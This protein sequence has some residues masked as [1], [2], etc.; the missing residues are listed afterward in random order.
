M[1]VRASFVP[2][3]LGVATLHARAVA[4]PA[5]D[6]FVDLVQGHVRAEALDVFLGDGEWSRRAI[7]WKVV[8][9][10]AAPS[11][12]AFDLLLDAALLPE[13]EASTSRDV[14]WAL[15]PGVR[16]ALGTF[17]PPSPTFDARDGPSSL[18]A[19][20]DLQVYRGGFE[21]G[22]RPVLRVAPS[23]G[24]ID[25]DEAWAAWRGAH[26]HA[27][28][29][30]RDRWLGPG[31]RGALL[32]TD[33]A[34]P[35]PMGTIAAF[36]HLPG[37]LTRA[38]NF[39]FETSL[40][41]FD[42]PR[43]DVRHPLLLLADARW[44]P[45]PGLEIGATRMSL[46]GGEDRAWPSLGQILVPS[47]PHVYDDPE[48]EQPDQ[49]ELA[50]LDV[51]GC[52]PLAR[53]VGGPVE[54]IEAWWQYGAED[55]VM[56]EIGGVSVPSLAAVAF[57]YG[58]EAQLGPW[59]VTAEQARIFDDTFRWYTHHRVYHEGFTQDGRVLGHEAG[60][61]ALD[62]WARV[63][64]RPRPYRWMAEA[65][66]EHLQRIGVVASQGGNLLALATDETSRRV[67]V[68]VAFLRP[69]GGSVR[70][71]YACEHV[72]GADFVPGAT[73]WNHH[74]L[75]SWTSG[76]LGGTHGRVIEGH[77][78][79]RDHEESQRAS[80]N[81][82]PEE[83]TGVGLEAGGEVRVSPGR[84]EHPRVEDTPPVVPD[85]DQAGLDPSGGNPTPGKP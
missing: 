48:R 12:Q 41:W 64:Y 61:D 78:L 54:W 56:R 69:R 9:G 5:A 43:E 40:G 60:G 4:A 37:R 31:R 17:A 39:R 53:L 7:A 11:W 33:N 24:R 85:E 65:W 62:L 20:L 83:K 79:H 68:R 52:L 25:L 72:A 80:R 50:S 51:R 84:G 34:R 47:E 44:L 38:G 15:R 32:L 75:V 21:V 27:G 28:F 76:W 74:A 59:R 55:L 63:G 13:R 36:G 16:S 67:G 57:L 19:D 81:G 18:R 22:L 70:V 23:E 49:D 58:L 29:G 1:P 26:L 35:P 46:F 45:V 73:E 82:C 71:G 3:V 77:R 42:R 30:W 14:R 10:P 66:I 2:V 6:P 8:P